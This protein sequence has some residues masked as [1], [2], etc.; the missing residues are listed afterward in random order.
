MGN[1]LKNTRKENWTSPGKSLSPEEFKKGIKEAEKGPFY[2]TED[3]KKI[4]STWKKEKLQ[5]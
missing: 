2:T 3:S 4:V 1:K 5:K